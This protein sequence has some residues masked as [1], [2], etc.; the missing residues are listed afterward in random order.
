MKKEDMEAVALATWLK[1][2]KYRFTHIANESWLPPKIAMLSA[3]KKKKMWLSPGI[4]DFMIVLKT[5]WLLFL[6]LK[7]TLEPTDYRRDWKLKSSAP[8]PSDEQLEWLQT[9]A[10]IDNVDAIVAYW[11]EQA[12]NLISEYDN[13]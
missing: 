11:Y 6:E 12:K 3:I 1:C 13:N 2:N 5:W 7:R 9:L 8:C 10:D 4:P